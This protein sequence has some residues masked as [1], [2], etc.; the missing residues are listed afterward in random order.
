M[1]EIINKICTRLV[2]NPHVIGIIADWDILEN[3]KNDELDMRRIDLCIISKEAGN[4]KTTY[5]E[6]GFVI[7]LQWRTQEQ[8]LELVKHNHPRADE[9]RILYDRIGLLKKTLLKSA[10]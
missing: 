1:V 2:S 7:C 5:T 4:Q 6:E 9:K 10:V 8:F 3:E